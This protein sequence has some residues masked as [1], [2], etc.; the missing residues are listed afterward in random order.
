VHDLPEFMTGTPRICV[1]DV[2]DFDAML[3]RRIGGFREKLRDWLAPHRLTL[4]EARI[5]KVLIPMVGV[6]TPGWQAMPAVSWT[7]VEL[8]TRE[9]VGPDV[10]LRFDS[11]GSWNYQEARRILHGVRDCDIEFVEQPMNAMLP[12]RFY[13]DSESVPERGATE[14][15]YQHELYFRR[16]TELRREQP[17]PLFARIGNMR[18]GCTPTIC[19]TAR[20]APPNPA[21]RSRRDPRRFTATP[22]RMPWRKSSKQRTRRM[23]MWS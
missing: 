23:W 13:P 21:G 3:K 4:S 6:Y 18:G 5:H 8:V 9:A 15:S 10:M 1:D 7:F 19:S 2:R 22:I 14:G 11:H 20:A 17:I 16:M 12:R